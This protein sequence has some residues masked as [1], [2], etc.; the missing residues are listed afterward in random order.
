MALGLDGEPGVELGVRA[1]HPLEAA[2]GLDPLPPVGPQ[3]LQQR[4]RGRLLRA[5]ATIDRSTSDSTALGHVRSG[6]EA[7]TAEATSGSDATSCSAA[8]RGNRP[9]KADS[10]SNTRCEGSSSRL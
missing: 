1:A 6:P 9:A 10:T 7:T 3:R 5:A 8:V 2:A 4:I